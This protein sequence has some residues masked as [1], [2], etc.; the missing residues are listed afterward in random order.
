MPDKTEVNVK[1]G[2]FFKNM[3][4]ELKKV[5]WPTRAQT[6]KS[7]GTVVLFVL[8]ITLILVVLNMIFENI[9][10]N[11]WALFNK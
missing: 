2:S 11:Y 5:I 4:A 6:A 8:I 7:T 3:V 1:K 9:N 10:I